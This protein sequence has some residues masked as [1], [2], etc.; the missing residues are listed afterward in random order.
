MSALRP[1]RFFLPALLPALLVV[2]VTGCDRD[3]DPLTP[4]PLP[5][6]AVVFDDNFG[7][8][9]DFQAFAG[10]KTDA[11]QRDT[12][13]RYEGEASLRI[14]VPAP[15]DPSGSYAGGAFVAAVPR[16]LSQYNAITFWARGDREGSLDV[17][18]IGNDNTGESL[19]TAETQNLALTTSWQQYV[20]PIPLP[21]ALDSERGLFYFAD[22]GEAYTIWMDD[23]RFDQVSGLGTPRPAIADRTLSV[24][25]GST[26]TVTG[27]VVAWTVGGEELVVTAAPSYFTFTSSD[28][29]VATVS[30]RGEIE[31]VGEGIATI[32]ASLGDVEAAGAVTINTVEGPSEAA[33]TPTRDAADVISLFSNAYE[34]VPV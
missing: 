24:E 14:T 21:S 30:D 22:G 1:S 18:G 17:A 33:P 9:V 4:A 29:A 27:T 25:V 3:D 32:T 28:P 8:G 5:D 31:V 7:D 13:E 11:L 6:D 10:S 2:A 26:A 12:S 16:D 20:I 19:F 15:D 23:I 34:N